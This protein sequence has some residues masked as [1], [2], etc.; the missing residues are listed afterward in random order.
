M[1]AESRWRAADSSIEPARQERPE[2]LL[3][4]VGD[5]GRADA[6]V[7][8]DHTQPVPPGR[9]DHIPRQDAVALDAI[10]LRPL[11]VAHAFDLH[12]PGAGQRAELL[13]PELLGRYE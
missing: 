9:L 13:P 2:L 8:L 1:Y 3:H 7:H 4:K 6:A 5:L 10:A 11:R 12:G